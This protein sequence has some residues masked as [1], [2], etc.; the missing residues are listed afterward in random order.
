MSITINTLSKKW[1]EHIYD[2]NERFEWKFTI[3][4]KYK[5]NK[6]VHT[7]TDEEI[8]NIFYQEVIVKWWDA[9]GLDKYNYKIGINNLPNQLKEIYL[10]EHTK[11]Q[12]TENYRRIALDWWE[13][14]RD[15]VKEDYFIEYKSKVFTQAL[16]Y[17]E[18][19]GREIQN[20]W[21]VKTDTKEAEMIPEQIEQPQSVL[22]TIDVENVVKGDSDLWYEI[23]SQHPITWETPAVKQVIQYIQKHYSLIKK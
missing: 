23:Y 17:T 8:E 12:P 1:W 19:T 16:R 6:D 18:L 13:K 14:L 7:L 22:K 3:T 9:K 11:E 15:A 21:A 10:K 4:L 2:A 20:I 5:L